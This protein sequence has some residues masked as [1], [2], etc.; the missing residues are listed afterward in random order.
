MNCRIYFFLKIT[1]TIS[2][3]QKTTGTEITQISLTS[4]MVYSPA[5]K[6]ETNPGSGNPKDRK[7]LKTS[8]RGSQ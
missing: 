1:I 8:I 5:S 2:R 6:L 4:Q 3:E 7:K